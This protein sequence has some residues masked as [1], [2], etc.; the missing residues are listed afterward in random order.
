MEGAT[1]QSVIRELAPY[2]DEIEEVYNQIAPIRD[3]IFSGFSIYTETV[4]EAVEEVQ[5]ALNDMKSNFTSALMDMTNSAEDFSKDISKIMAQNFIE[6]FVLGKKFDQ[7]MEYW[8]GQYENIISAGY[9]D[10]ERKRQLKQLRDTIAAAKEGYVEE[11]RAIQELLGLDTSTEDRKANV[12]IAD[13]ITYD[14][15]DEITSMLRAIQIAGEQ[16]N[17][18]IRG[19]GAS[20]GLEALAGTGDT[21]TA[22]AIRTTLATLSS[23]GTPGGTE[24][25]EIRNMMIT[26][27]QYLLDIQKSNR[28]ILNNFGTKMD[29]IIDKLDDIG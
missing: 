10:V 7:Q 17:D 20:I 5:Y 21:A 23:V 29:S 2:I 15:A 14:Q 13:K 27:N 1:I 19:I 4:E 12:A 6:N 16:R 28:A 9:S 11:A 26:T 25:K 22:D 8:Q 18:L 24:V 3:E